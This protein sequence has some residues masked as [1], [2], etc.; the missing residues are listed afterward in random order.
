[1]DE[2]LVLA[3]QAG[4]AGAAGASM[5]RDLTERGVGAG[6]HRLAAGIGD[7]ADRAKLVGVQDLIGVVEKVLPDV[8]QRVNDK[9]IQA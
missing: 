8:G 6:A 4:A 5:G 2:A 7:R 1:M 9:R 3:R